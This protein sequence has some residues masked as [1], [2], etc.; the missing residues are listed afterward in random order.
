MNYQLLRNRK[1]GKNMKVLLITLLGLY[2][3]FNCIVARLLGARGMKKRFID[4][5]CIIGRIAANIFYS[6]AWFLKG[7]K[8]VVVKL[9]K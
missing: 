5:Q 2:L 9:I 1:G 4:G 8:F 7:V 6:P 3:I